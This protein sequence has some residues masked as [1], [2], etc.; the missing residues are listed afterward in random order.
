[1]VTMVHLAEKMATVWHPVGVLY[2]AVHTV[3]EAG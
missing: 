3:A 1:M 2:L